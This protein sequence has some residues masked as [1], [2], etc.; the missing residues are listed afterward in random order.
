MV[1]TNRVLEAIAETRPT[2]E[3]ALLEIDGVGEVFVTRY[4]EPVL[5]LIEQDGW[6][7]S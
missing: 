1:A 2:D 7:A 4:A 3:A 6:E 5:M